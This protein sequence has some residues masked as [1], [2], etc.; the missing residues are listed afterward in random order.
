[1]A[2]HTGNQSKTYYCAYCGR[3]TDWDD[4]YGAEPVCVDC[5]DARAG[6]EHEVA[7]RK[8]RYREEHKKLKGGTK[9]NGR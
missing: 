1:M 8:R 3:A 5:W 2:A 7:A 9:N 4:D 6:S